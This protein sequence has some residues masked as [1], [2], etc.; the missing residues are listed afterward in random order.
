MERL[1]QLWKEAVGGERRGWRSWPAS[2]VWARPAWP[3][4]SPGRSTTRGDRAG[5]ALRRGPRRA[6]PAV[7]RGAAP[8][9][10]PRRR[11]RTSPMRLGRYGGEL[12]RLVPGVAERV[13]GLPPRCSP[14]RRRAVPA[15]RRG[16]RLA[17]GRLEPT[18]RS[19]RARRPPVGGQADAA[20]AAPRRSAQPS[21]RGCWSSAPTGTPNCAT[22]IRWSSSSPTSAARRESSGSRSTGLD[23]SGVAR[24]MEQRRSQ[25]GRRGAA[26]A[27]AIYQETEGNPFFVRE[28]LRHLAESGT[29][30]PAGRGTRDP[31]RCPGGG[32]PAAGPP[33]Q[34]DQPC[35]AGGRGGGDGVRAARRPG[36]RASRRGGS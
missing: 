32:G 17:G 34:G 18:I 23:E 1:E 11:P 21:R 2:R 4:S 9:R 20:A 5:R 24:F 30:R 26:L 3:P 19:A 35:A 8:L 10:G 29:D 28:V 15:L 12:V 31:R 14:T 22:T 33:V 7:R 36:G 25:P 27:R 16:G 13:P 6:V